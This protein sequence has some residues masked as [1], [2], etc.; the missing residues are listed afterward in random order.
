[1]GP[2][3]LTTAPA[4]PPLAVEPKRR[5][6]RWRLV[7]VL[8]LLAVTTRLPAFFVD[9]FN[10]DE[11]FLATQAEVI[12]DGGELYE[13]TTDRKPPLVPYVYAVAFSL[14]GSTGLWTVRVFAMLAVVLTALLL[15]A[16]ARRRWG[17]RAGWFAGILFVLASVAFA[18]QD[19]QAANFEIFML[20][21]MV[22]S[23]MLA[24][25]RRPGAAGVAAAVATLAKQTGALT[26]LPLAYLVYKTRRTEGL[27]RLLTGFTLP[28]VATALIF[29]P[30][31]FFYWTLLGNGS[32]VGMDT[33]SA[34]V[35]MMFAVMTMAWALCNLPIVWRLP[36]AWRERA[37]VA[38]DGGNDIDLW[39]WLASAAVSVAIGLRFF[40]HYY[41]Q[42]LPPACLLTAGAL[43]RGKSIVATRTIAVAAIAAVGF[44]L[45][46][47]FIQPFKEA[48][49]YQTVCH[50]L[51]AN[52][53][54]GDRALVWGS[55]PEIYWCSGLTP[56]TRFVTTGTYLAGN[57]PGRAGA[58]A[59]PE[60][61]DPRAWHW[62]FEDL[63]A[64]PPRYVLDTSAAAIRGAE[65]TP[66]GRFPRLEALL[67][68]KYRSV[69][70]IDGITI[71]E[72]RTPV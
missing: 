20:P 21:A 54:P 3:P 55:V 10:S 49:Q 26:L 37:T 66:I 59:A 39:L 25:R 46:A 58:D 42:L 40:G 17:E 64:H 44:S 23:I 56:A 60:E 28:I 61:A 71:Y 72:R 4:A 27:G 7:L 35:L 34:T 18:P 38:D 9:V 22:A 47:F 29:G 70:A 15:A 48:A 63:D 2:V 51:E 24:R 36:Q 45:V 16:E 32:Y 43:T 12:R 19:G 13:D 5:Q 41:L 6:L 30:G 67:E 53:G 68:T 11:T 50:Y 14:F 33:L 1:M 52:S 8:L 69:G 31:E 65:Y 57:H 62:F